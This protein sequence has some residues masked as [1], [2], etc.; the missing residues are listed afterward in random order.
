MFKL[1][2]QKCKLDVGQETDMEPP[3]ERQSS[4]NTVNLSWVNAEN[5]VA[6]IGKVANSPQK[7]AQVSLNTRWS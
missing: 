4:H 7:E 3:G 1:N 5:H 2:R 6:T